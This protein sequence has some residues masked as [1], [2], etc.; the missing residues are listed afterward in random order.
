MGKGHLP[1]TKISS[2][3]VFGGKRDWEL[4]RKREVRMREYGTEGT[5][6]EEPKLV[7]DVRKAVFPERIV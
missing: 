6:T 4:R 2:I 3:Q 7:L 1:T 5:Q